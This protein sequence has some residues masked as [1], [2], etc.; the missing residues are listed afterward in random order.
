MIPD[1][2]G[3][4][5]EYVVPVGTLSVPFVGATLKLPVEQIV[6]VLFAITGV[7]LT[8][9]DTLKDD[10]EH[11]YGDDPTTRT[12]IEFAGEFVKNGV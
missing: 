4:D 10:P 2:D 3:A 9:T 5:Q 12:P 6:C 7:G 8:T 11:V 1:T